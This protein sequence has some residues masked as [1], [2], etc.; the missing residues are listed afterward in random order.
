MYARVFIIIKLLAAGIII[1]FK[2]L[3]SDHFFFCTYSNNAKSLS[4]HKARMCIIIFVSARRTPRRTSAERRGKK[5]V[6]RFDLR[7]SIISRSVVIT[8]YSRVK[9][10]AFI[11]VYAEREMKYERATY[12]IFQDSL[13]NIFEKI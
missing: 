8:G 12:T 3:R 7:A 2:L 4:I 13:T 5:K 10:Y 1:K 11:A 9:F 6:T